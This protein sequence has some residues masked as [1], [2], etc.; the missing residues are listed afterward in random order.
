MNLIWYQSGVIYPIGKTTHGLIPRQPYLCYWGEYF[1]DSDGVIQ[2]SPRWKNSKQGVIDCPNFDTWESVNFRRKAAPEYVRIIP[3]PTSH[4]ELWNSAL[5]NRPDNDDLVLIYVQSYGGAL[6]N[7]SP[8]CYFGKFRH[9]PL[10]EW[11]IFR[12]RPTPDDGYRNEHM[13]IEAS[14]VYWLPL[15][16][17]QNRNHY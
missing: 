9:D 10:A 14:L 2:K 3:I 13:K 15:P 7:I 8:G 5:T 17:L 6:Y 16:P 12:A 11:E 4:P 1:T